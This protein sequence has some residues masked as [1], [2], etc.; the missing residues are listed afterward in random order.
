MQSNEVIEITKDEIRPT[1]E[2]MRKEGKVIPM[3]HCYLDKDGLPVV[4]YDYDFGP[5]VKS[6]VVKGEKVL[7]TISDIYDQAAAW[8]EREINELMD[9]TFE[10]LDVSKRL[11][12]PES[13]LEGQGHIF[14]TP[15]EDLIKATHH[16]DEEEEEA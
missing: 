4:S 11:F 6:Y 7:P 12:L 14:V 8:P 16:K 13:M 3:I 2:K 1:A 10:G 9:V 15:M 5:V